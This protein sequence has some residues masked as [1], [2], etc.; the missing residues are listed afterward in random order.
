[1]P[2]NSETVKTDCFR[3]NNP[4]R[5]DPYAFAG[6]IESG[7]AGKNPMIRRPLRTHNRWAVPGALPRR[8]PL[9]GDPARRPGPRRRLAPADLPHALLR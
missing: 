9:R 7:V 4:I 6:F 5:V 1:M 2:A 8:R 3:P